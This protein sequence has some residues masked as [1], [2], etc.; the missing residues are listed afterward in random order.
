M[1]PRPVEQFVRLAAPDRA[2]L[3]RAALLLGATR[4]ALWLL[5]LRVVRRLL[6][7]SVR[8]ARAP[9]PTREGIGW[10]VSTARRVV[11]RATCLPQ[12]LVA[13]A[14]LLGAGHPAHLRI[15]VVKTAPGRLEAHAWVE[16]QGLIVVGQLHEDLSRY[17]PLPPLPGA[18]GDATRQ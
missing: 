14:L 13:E 11:P 17:T 3:V 8:P 10:A 12:A 2:L 18:Q 1:G 5:P 4:L 16:S 6:V 9:R 7:R 15:G